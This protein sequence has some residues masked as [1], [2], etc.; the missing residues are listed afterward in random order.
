EK[1]VVIK[2]PSQK[3]ESKLG[4]LLREKFNLS[5]IS[6]L[7]ALFAIFCSPFVQLTWGA[8]AII[9]FIIGFICAFGALIIE[10]I[11]M[12]KENVFEFNL[13]LLL[14]GLS[15]FVLFI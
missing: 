12:I 8:V 1:K 15:F 4:N 11:K 14:I 5:F 7:L 9:F 2:E 3:R 13:K 10:M 6:V